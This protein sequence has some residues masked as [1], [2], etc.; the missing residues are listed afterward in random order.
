MPAE[1]RTLTSWCS[2]RGRDQVIGQKPTPHQSWSDVPIRVVRWSE[3]EFRVP[4]TWIRRILLFKKGP[5]GPANAGEKVLM[6]LKALH[7]FWL[8]EAWSASIAKKC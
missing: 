6:V 3:R 1:K 7:R 5:R 2:R 8:G 4:H